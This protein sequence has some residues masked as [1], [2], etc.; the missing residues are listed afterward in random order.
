[1]AEEQPTHV[2]WTEAVLRILSVWLFV[3][4]AIGLPT[5]V[6]SW[7]AVR[8]SAPNGTQPTVIVLASAINVLARFVVA[9]W[10]WRSGA[11]RLA[12]VIW[13]G[14]TP[15]PAQL[16][17]NPG[18]LQRAVCA[19]LG[20]YVIVSA[21]PTMAELGAGFYRLRSVFGNQVQYRTD[22]LPRGI[23]AAAQCLVGAWLLF[24]ARGLAQLLVTL[25]Q[26]ISRAREAR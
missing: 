13:R 10:L 15:G 22:M 23:G 21:I 5:L 16:P 14:R 20:V 7:I 24:G 18:D 1:M 6:A 25:R 17:L 11:T 9:V 2:A 3:G 8:S 4:L 19:G 26:G 12:A